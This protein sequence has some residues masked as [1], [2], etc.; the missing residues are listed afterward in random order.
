MVMKDRLGFA[1]E[2]LLKIKFAL[3]WYLISQIILQDG[4]DL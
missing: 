2:R 4:H 3:K 1:R